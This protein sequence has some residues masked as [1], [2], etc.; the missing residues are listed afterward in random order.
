[1]QRRAQPKRAAALAATAAL[2]VA[3][4][5][6]AFTFAAPAAAARRCVGAEEARAAEEGD[7]PPKLSSRFS[8]RTFSLDV[9]LDGMEGSQVPISIEEV[10]DIPKSLRKQ[11]A[12]LAGNDGIARLT[13]QT[14][15]WKDRRRLA[16]ADAMTAVD[17]AD[18]A[19]LRV[20]LAP[21][22]RWGEDEDGDK[23]PTFVARRIVITD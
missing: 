17:G 15:V 21:R 7:T 13:T 1:V 22:P 8:T 12:V 5:P 16:A 2:A 18:T 23:V 6:L 11:A 10:C 20:R 9:S 3:A 14:S 19:T 4:L